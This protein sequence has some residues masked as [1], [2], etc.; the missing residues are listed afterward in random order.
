MN[1][2]GITLNTT[3][4]FE[5]NTDLSTF[6]EFEDFMSSYDMDDL[7]MMVTQKHESEVA[8]LE[9]GTDIEIEMV[10]IQD[11]TF[12]AIPE[13]PNRPDHFHNI[14]CDLWIEYVII[15]LDYIPFCWTAILLLQLRW[16]RPYRLARLIRLQLFLIYFEFFCI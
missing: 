5:Y 4:N 10:H 7:L 11:D 16:S 14:R 9:P 6:E 1:T 12:S 2:F 3:L 15:E 13:D 8:E